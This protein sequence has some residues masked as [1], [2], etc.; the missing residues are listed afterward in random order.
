MSHFRHYGPFRDDLPR[1]SE[2]CKTRGLLNQSLGRYK[3]KQNYHQ[4]R[5]KNET[6]THECATVQ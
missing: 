6:I 5:Q 2:R 3:M 1:K 4:E